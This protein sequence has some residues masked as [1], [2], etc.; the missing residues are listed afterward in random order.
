MKWL[1]EKIKLWFTE[2]YEL[3]VFFPGPTQVMPDGSRIE[4]GAPKTYQ[5]KKIK[6][7]TTKHIIFVD[8]DNKTHEIKM[9]SDV[10]YDLRKIY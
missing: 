2:E 7:L 5:C 1:L 4:S 8:M 9:V 10:G 3:T 6:K